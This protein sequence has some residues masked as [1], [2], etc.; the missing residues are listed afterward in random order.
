LASTWYFLRTGRVPL[1]G[2]QD[3]TLRCA[4]KVL[5]KQLPSEERSILA[6]ALAKTPDERYP[7]CGQFIAALEH[8]QFLDL[9]RMRIFSLAKTVGLFSSLLLSIFLLWL[10]LYYVPKQIATRFDRQGRRE[11][12][13]ANWDAARDSFSETLKRY[14]NST[15]ALTGRATA[16]IESGLLSDAVRDL[17]HA[18]QIDPLGDRIWYLRGV[19]AARRHREPAAI[20]AFSTAIEH[21]P[22][23]PEYYLARARQYVTVNKK[24]E[25]FKDLNQTIRLDPKNDEALALRGEIQTDFD[26]ALADLTAAVRLCPNN[27]THLL[28]RATLF[29][30]HGDNTLA[31]ADATA[32]TRLDKNNIQAT[33]LLAIIY[34][35]LGQNDKAEEQIMK[36]QQN[37]K[38]VEY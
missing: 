18:G 31:L 21:S 12:Q 1:G 3:L 29:M 2:A 19:V 32:V 5:S 35:R 30:E 13:L 26:S 36:A 15:A 16:L 23:N 11:L 20:H 22:N 17:D 14:P 7:S 8:A 28:R 4:K 25:A 24:P 10:L 38:N 6:R 34:E 27:P 9:R 37:S 33:L